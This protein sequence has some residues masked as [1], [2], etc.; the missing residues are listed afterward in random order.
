MP[1]LTRT[2]ASPYCTN[3]NVYNAAAA[4]VDKVRT[5]HSGIRTALY[6]LPISHGLRPTIQALAQESLKHADALVAGATTVGLLAAVQAIDATERVD[7]HRFKALPAFFPES[8]VIVLAYELLVGPRRK[9]KGAH[10]GSVALVR[11]AEA[12][13]R[14]FFEANATTHPKTA[15]AIAGKAKSASNDMAFP[16][17]IRVN[18]LKTTVAKAIAGLTKAGLK[19]HV[20]ETVPE[21]LVLPPGTNLHGHAL[22]KSGAVFVQ[23]LASCLPVAAIPD[24]GRHHIAVDACAA[25]GNKTTQL[26]ARLALAHPTSSSVVAFERAPARATSLRNTVAKAGANDRITVVEADFLETNMAQGPWADATLAICDPSCSGSGNVAVGEPVPEHSADEL[27]AFADHQFAIVQQAMALPKM[28]TVVYSTC[29]V[30]HVENE[31]VVAR[32]LKAHGAKWALVSVLPA[33]PERG[34]ES[35][36]LAPRVTKRCVRASHAQLTHGFFVSCF[37]RRPEELAP[38]APSRKRPVDAVT[39]PTAGQAT[40]KQKK[41]K[42]KKKKPTTKAADA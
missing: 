4:V 26:A 27:A 15:A 11:D 24:I 9:L 35:D 13:L 5:K 8:L 25:P 29:S 30:H 16:R 28:Q 21:L 3:M 20:H 41:K 38:E 37:E 39:A 32:L 33:W 23:D 12:A 14:S 2:N 17:Y 10:A 6:A 34:V 40:K 31:G 22:V 1:L 42:Q 36:A 19:P 7:A 18:T